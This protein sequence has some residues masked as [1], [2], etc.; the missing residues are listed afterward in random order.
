MQANIQRTLLELTAISVSN[1]VLKFDRDM[2]LLCGGGA[3][4]SFLVDRIKAMMPNVEV[5][6]ARHGDMLEAMMMAW[7]A[8][9]RVRS[10][11][12]ELKD[13]TGASANAV[14]GGLYV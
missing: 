1:E 11:K 12:V 14:L 2:V 6:I 10:E 4:N 9:K 7:L 13:I 8:Y 3:K 5:L